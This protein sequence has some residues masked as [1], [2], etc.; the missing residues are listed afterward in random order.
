[1]TPPA[2]A[3][4]VA[5]IW[6]QHRPA[7]G[8]RLDTLD[9]AVDGVGAGALASESLAEALDAAR[10]LAGTAGTFDLGRASETARRIEDLLRDAPRPGQAPVLAE[11]VAGLREDLDLPALAGERTAAPVPAPGTL[12]LV[13]L[14]TA[15][16]SAAERLR[17][18]AERR[19]L[20]VTAGPDPDTAERLIERERPD[21]V[22]LDVSRPGA[23]E[24]I[25][26]LRSARAPI[27]VVALAESGSPGERLELAQLG[28][29][30]FLEPQ[31]AAAVVMD[32]VAL[33]LQQSWMPVPHVVV[34][35]TDDGCAGQ[36]RE[37][38]EPAGLEVELAADPSE[39][40]AAVARGE[41][42]LLIL[43][44][45]S[46]GIDGPALCRAL[47]LDR[48][49]A[50]VPVVVLTDGTGVAPALAAGAD[51][52][53]LG[54]VADPEA[55]ARIRRHLERFHTHQSLAGTDPLTGLDDRRSA[56]TTLA[57][58]IRLA[59]RLDRPMCVVAIDVPDQSELRRTGRRLRDGLR[60]EDV[61]ARWSAEGLVVGM[62]GV[63][64]PVA[65]DRLRV[66][67]TVGFSAGVAQYPQDGLNLTALLDAARQAVQAAAFATDVS[68]VAAGEPHKW[69]QQVDV[70]IVEDEDAAAELMDLGLSERGY[71]CW[72]FSNGA[73]AVA[74]LVGSSPGVHARVILLDLT[75]P[76]VDGIEL[77]TLLA[78]DGIL[79]TTRVVV[80]SGDD[81][82]A[83]IARCSAIGAAEYLIK[84]VPIERLVATV[85]GVLGRRSV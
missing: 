9:R 40:W 3:P 82:P 1:V 16:E 41:E 13:L 12:P 80:V 37:T 81:D 52:A 64:R 54:P 61:I 6:Q 33:V 45:G 49:S 15:D 53:I 21:A 14:I 44:D 32:Q 43:D 70:A 73:G 11:L 24:L 38:L 2:L 8:A 10:E 31:A 20:R 83:L 68:V 48:R 65:T 85:D 18:E 76:A 36:V 23:A 22:L 60:S 34:V 4:T 55:L 35:T 56:A 74:K 27:P 57:R 30:G 77:L 28:V 72:R 5:A 42:A 29:A 79:Q 69:T 51:D 59:E 78:R 46:A 50:A 17:L 25:G 84:P 71:S 75:L 39:L 63:Q 7:M 19:A 62:F 26:R 67:S 47:R 66:L 58:Q